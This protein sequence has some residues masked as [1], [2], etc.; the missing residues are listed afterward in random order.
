MRWFGETDDDWSSLYVGDDGRLHFYR[1]LDNH[2]EHFNDAEFDRYPWHRFHVRR[3][4]NRAH[5]TVLNRDHDV[6]LA[7]WFDPGPLNPTRE[8]GF[9]GSAF[10]IGMVHFDAIELDDRYPYPGEFAPIVATDHFYP[11]VVESVLDGIEELPEGT[12]VGV[13]DG[14]LCVG[15]GFT[16]DLGPLVISAYRETEEQSGYVPGEPMRFMVTHDELEPVEIANVWWHEGGGLFED[17]DFARVTLNLNEM[18]VEDGL[19]QPLE[20]AVSRAW[21]NPFNSSTAVEV[22][23]PRAGEVR[24]ALYNVLGRAVWSQVRSSDA[25]VR[26]VSLGGASSAVMGSGVYFLEVRAEGNLHRQ[27]VVMVK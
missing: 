17:A 16:S 15:R 18:D 2:I 11:V 4:G 21:P 27:R 25:G 19:A 5:F 24:L 9:G 6:V 12:E 13:F 1:N 14:D 3:L 10:P 22:T 23:L 8:I 20:F 7:D 26:T